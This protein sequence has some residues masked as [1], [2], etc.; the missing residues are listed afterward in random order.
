[1]KKLILATAL[2]SFATF[3]SSVWAADSHHPTEDSTQTIEQMT[4]DQTN[5]TTIDLEKMRE[6][7]EQET[8]PVKRQNLMHQHMEMMREGMKMMSMMGGKDQGMSHDGN[9]Q[10]SMEKRMSMMEQKMTM[11]ENMMSRMMGGMMG[12]QHSNR[13]DNRM[14]IMEDKMNMLQEMMN[15][16]LMQQ[17]MMDTSNSVHS[18]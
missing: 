1:M 18:K 3:A 4:M 7:I 11:M 15:G 12:M 13:E 5:T 6:K 9:E 10:T 16:M 14:Q 17:E 2:V 8:D